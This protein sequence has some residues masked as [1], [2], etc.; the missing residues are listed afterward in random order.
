MG[1]LIR[2]VCL[3][4]ALLTAAPASATLVRAVPMRAMAAQA[5]EVIRGH[6]L[7][8]ECLYDPVFER[9]YT[10]TRLA[11]LETLAGSTTRGDVI[12]VRQIGGILDGI[13]S[14][15]VGTARLEMG[16]EVV[17]FTR[18]DGAHHYLMGMAQGAYAV[19]RRAPGAPTLHRE[20]GALRIAPPF[21]P[22][23][24]LAPDRLTLDTLRTFVVEVRHDEVQP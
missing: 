10:H 22:A 1:R 3:A 15:V 6:V 11:V 8:S 5:H 14:R 17:L 21:G 19:D 4:A 9:V 12:E 13:E 20:T 2:G 7:D 24:K 16:A 18:T 23:A